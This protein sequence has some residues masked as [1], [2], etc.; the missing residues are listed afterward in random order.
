[1]RFLVE[2][3]LEERH[4]ES[5]AARE[6]NFAY[7]GELGVTVYRSKAHESS[8]SWTPEAGSA[9]SA[10]SLQESRNPKKPL[11]FHWDGSKHVK[12]NFMRWGWEARGRIL[13]ENTF[14]VLPKEEQCSICRE[15]LSVQ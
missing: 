5:L 6:A 8:A 14:S 7:F 3:M 9:A 15:E 2:Q 1:M 12:R 11:F 4:A 10:M 13:P